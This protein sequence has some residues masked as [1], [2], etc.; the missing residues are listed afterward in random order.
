M[1][2]STIAEV[3]E[4]FGAELKASG[5]HVDKL[6]LFGSHAS[7]QPDENSDIDI[8]VVSRDFENRDIFGRVK[9]LKQAVMATIGRFVV[10]LDVVPLTPGEFDSRSSPMASF[11]R[12]GKVIAEG[13]KGR[14]Y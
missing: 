7:G 11:A 2:E 13:I 9:L 12:E 5:I 14:Q 1:V 3:I 6:V 8:A 4:F 10:P